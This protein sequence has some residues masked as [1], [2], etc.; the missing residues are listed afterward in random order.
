[1]CFKLQICICWKSRFLYDNNCFAKKKINKCWQIVL[2]IIKW[3]AFVQLDGWSPPSDVCF[4]LATIYGCC[5]V[6]HKYIFCDDCCKHPCLATKPPHS[7]AVLITLFRS[8][9]LTWFYIFIDRHN[10]YTNWTFTCR[11]QNIFSGIV[12]FMFSGLRL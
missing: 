3:T 9:C 8:G 2:F 10:R 11:N 12:I 1:M 4:M 7:A 6:L 5:L